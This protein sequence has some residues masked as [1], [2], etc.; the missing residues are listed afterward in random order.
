VSATPA[1]SGELADRVAAVVLACPSVTGLW[2][3]AGGEVATH[4]VGRRVPGVRVMPDTVEVHVSIRWTDPLSD[5]A[6]EVRAAVAPVVGARTTVVVIE[7]VDDPAPAPPAEVSQ[8][9]EQVPAPASMP[10]TSGSA[11]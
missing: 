6:D 10:A 5:A 8:P 2:E 9:T 1:A 7:E 3:G 4:L 11:S